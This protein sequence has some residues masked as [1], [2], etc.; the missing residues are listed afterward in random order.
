MQA[1]PYRVARKLAHTSEQAMELA[2]NI[3][4]SNGFKVE[5]LPG[6]AMNAAGLNAT[7]PGMQSKRQNPLLG[8]K[9]LTLRI[10]EGH[11]AID[12]DLSAMQRLKRF[13]YWFPWGL[14][15]VLAI[16]LGT[17]FGFQFG[18]QTESGFGIPQFEGWKWMVLVIVV[19]LAPALPWLILSPLLAR[20]L[21]RRTKL[22]IDTLC[23][24]VAG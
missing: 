15:L 17:I 23:V 20:S 19:G 5:S 21:E 7:G 16:T 4:A 6:E 10:A 11:V 3:L 14:S 1:E 12:A 18:S 9:H 13:V 24:N 2:R 22:A 8:A